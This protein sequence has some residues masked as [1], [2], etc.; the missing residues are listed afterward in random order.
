M[1]DLPTPAQQDATARRFH[2]RRALVTPESEQ[3]TVGRP[4]PLSVGASP[5]N[6][7]RRVSWIVFVVCVGFAVFGAIRPRVNVIN[8]NLGD[9]QNFQVNW[10][11]FGIVSFVAYW[12]LVAAFLYLRACN[13]QIS[14]AMK[15]IPDLAQIEAQLRAE[16]YNPSI[17]DLVAMHQHLTSQRN[18]AALVAGAL[19]MGSQIL[20]RQAQGKPIL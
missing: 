7:F 12:V 15:P 13:R 17:A 5:R 6:Y 4:I 8:D 1:S 18:E 9:Y 10:L 16:G 2:G 19:V 11:T 14:V 3:E 20:A